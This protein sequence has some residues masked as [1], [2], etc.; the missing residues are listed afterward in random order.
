MGSAAPDVE[1]PEP[2]AG[3]PAVTGGVGP[4]ALPGVEVPEPGAARLPAAVCR[5]LAAAPPVTEERTGLSAWASKRLERLRQGGEAVA[6]WT[7]FLLWI[8]TSVQDDWGLGVEEVNGRGQME[9]S[10]GAVSWR[11]A[12]S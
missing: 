10:H 8:T 3:A 5:E 2:M 1:P 9:V 12:L 11:A 7:L 4:E 6:L